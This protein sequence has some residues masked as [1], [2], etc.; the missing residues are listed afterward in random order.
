[1]IWYHKRSH[2]VL[3]WDEKRPWLGRGGLKCGNSVPKFELDFCPDHWGGPF[4]PKPHEPS[5]YIIQ[6]WFASKKSHFRTSA[7]LTPSARVNI[8][9][10]TKATSGIPARTTYSCSWGL[11]LA[12]SYTGRL[13][14][15]L[16]VKAGGTWNSSAGT[17]RYNAELFCRLKSR[18]RQRDMHGRQDWVNMQKLRWKGKTGSMMVWAGLQMGVVREQSQGFMMWGNREKRDAF[19]YTYMKRA[20]GSDLTSIPI[21]H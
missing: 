8:L 6:T 3:F 2:P 13:F 5:S 21:C 16:G 7:L 1:M 17:R 19:K 4:G 15:L 12:K 11:L 20:S 10:F 9:H 18:I 14:C